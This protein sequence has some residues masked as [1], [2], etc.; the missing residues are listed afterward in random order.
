MGQ[1]SSDEN[2]ETLRKLQEMQYNNA[3][4]P[5][6]MYQQESIYGFNNMNNDQGQYIEQKKADQKVLNKMVNHIF[7]DNNTIRFIET[8]D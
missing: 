3:N 8:D 1:G 2:N 4:A 7:V 6:H 5:T